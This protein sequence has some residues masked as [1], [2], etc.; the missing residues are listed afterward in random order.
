MQ[1]VVTKRKK[2]HCDITLEQLV[3]SV[4]R[5][6]VVSKTSDLCLRIANILALP[7]FCIGDVGRIKN[8]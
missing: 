8:L 6:I 7:T 2:T 5:N 4:T 3:R 1:N